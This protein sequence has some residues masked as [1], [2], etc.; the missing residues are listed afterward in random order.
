MSTEFHPQTDGQ[1]DKANS[2][3]ERYLYYT[4]ICIYGRCAI[5]RNISKGNTKPI[6]KRDY[7]AFESAQSRTITRYHDSPGCCL[8]KLP[9]KDEHIYNP[10]GGEFRFSFTTTYIL[11]IYLPGS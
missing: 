1:A 3:V 6:I 9:L 5:E 2:T 4:P 11:S 10:P 8:Y 7:T